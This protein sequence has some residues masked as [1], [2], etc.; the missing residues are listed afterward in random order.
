MSR[1]LQVAAF[2]DDQTA[3]LDARSDAAYAVWKASGFLDSTSYKVFTDLR[4][5]SRACARRANKI[6]ETKAKNVFARL[7]KMEAEKHR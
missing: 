5:K 4:A 2:Y 3:R 1:M 7:R 6:R